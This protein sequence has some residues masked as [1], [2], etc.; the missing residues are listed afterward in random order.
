MLCQ[1]LVAHAYNPSNS[2]SRDQED[3]CLKSAL[4]KM[5]EKPY[6]KKTHHKKKKKGWWSGCVGPE[7][8]SLYH[9]KKVYVVF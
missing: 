5:F 9:K 4:G 6:F 1:G 2:G 8:N 7:F 3:C